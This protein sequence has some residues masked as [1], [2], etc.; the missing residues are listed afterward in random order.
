LPITCNQKL[1]SG[2]GNAGGKPKDIV[3]LSSTQT[4]GASSD[5]NI[6]NDI[7][8]SLVQNKK[9]VMPDIR[10]ALTINQRKPRLFISRPMEV[11]QQTRRKNLQ[12]G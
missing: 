8:L 12:A 7:E 9:Q 6:K 5:V 3:T 4:T 11:L 1:V 10:Q 2:T